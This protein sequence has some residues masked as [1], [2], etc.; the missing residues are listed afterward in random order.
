MSP[1][2]SQTMR[3]IEKT[4]IFAP[5]AGTRSSIYPKLCMLIENVV[6]IVKG[7]NHFSIQCIVFPSGAKMLIFVTDALS[8]FNTVRLPWQPAGNNFLA[9]TQLHVFPL[10]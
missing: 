3:G 5:T 10:R 7:T 9:I 1:T 2:R 6:S 4:P 8:K